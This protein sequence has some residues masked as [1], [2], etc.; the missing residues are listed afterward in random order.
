MGITTILGLEAEEKK[1]IYSLSRG[2]SLKGIG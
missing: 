1:I 2:S